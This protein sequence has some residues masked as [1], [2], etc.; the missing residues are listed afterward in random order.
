MSPL[1][2]SARQSLLPEI[3]PEYDS[4]E[5]F[6]RSRGLKMT[7]QREAIFR[8]VFRY[9]GHIDAE[10]L[11]AR[12]RTIDRGASR[13]T[14]Y[15]TLD[16]LAQAGLV[17]RLGLEKNQRFYE[18]VHRDE[19]HDHLVCTVC[20]KIIEFYSPELEECQSGVCDEHSFVPASHTMV[21]FGKCR[22]CRK[23][24]R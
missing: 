1:K 2:N 19:H 7:R 17:K 11:T 23:K 22:E 6:L 9:H 13:A 14:V 5:A 12:M 18:H 10:E 20:G 4:F 24:K 8:E 21:I 3:K 15:R 16:L